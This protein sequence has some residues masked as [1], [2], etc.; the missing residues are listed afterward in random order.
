MFRSDQQPPGS[1]SP[2]R[3]T[4]E[5]FG[6][7]VAVLRDAPPGWFAL[8]GQQRS[9]GFLHC[10]DVA[11]HRGTDQVAAVQ[12]SRPVPESHRVRPVTTPLSE[13]WVFL[14]NTDRIPHRTF[15]ADLAPVRRSVVVHLDGAATRVDGHGSHGCTSASL[16]SGDGHLVVTAPDAH[17]A[18]AA[19]LALRGAGVF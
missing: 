16:P 13:L 18:V 2:D 19:D 4:V 7:P 11:Y 1:R 6:K 3:E 17:W 12:T 10:L 5:E 9:D 8:L 14:A 15:P